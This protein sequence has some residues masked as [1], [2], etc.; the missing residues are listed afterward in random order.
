MRQNFLFKNIPNIL[1]FYRILALPFL[2]YSVYYSKDELFILLLSINLI[3]DILDGLIAR[4]FKLETEFG[5][6]LDSVA[7]IGTLLMAFAGMFFLKRDFFDIHAYEFLTIFGF[8][9]AVHVISWLKFRRSPSLHLY[10]NKILGYI[11]GI[12]IFTYFNFGYNSI[13]FYFMI[14][15]S[16]LAYSEEI[17]CIL[18]LKEMKSNVKTFFHLKKDGKALN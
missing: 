8:Y 15:A 18:Y 14:F 12:F 3:S 13:Y 2:I 4:T 17:I 9:I 1:S 5:A 11:Q 10:S 16:I 6:K 7:D